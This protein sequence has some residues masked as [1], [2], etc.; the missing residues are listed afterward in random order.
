VEQATES[1]AATKGFGLKEHDEV[2]IAALKLATMNG[3]ILVPKRKREIDGMTIET[4][5]AESGKSD[6]RRKRHRRL[7]RPATT[8][9]VMIVEKGRVV[10][11]AASSWR[12]GKR[13][14][15]YVRTIHEDLW[16]LRLK[17]AARMQDW[18]L[19]ESAKI[20]RK[21]FDL[22]AGAPERRFEDAGIEVRGYELAVTPERSFPGVK[23][24]HDGKE[25]YDA[26]YERASTGAP[27]PPERPKLTL[28][29]DLGGWNETLQAL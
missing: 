9:S 19:A 16:I 6:R 13:K 10:F 29:M 26:V 28:R 3:Q 8:V 5:I 25:V 17:R 4:R 2:F 22:L 24:L 20:F 21:A 7:R 11:D 18:T 12:K 27:T 23:V 14:R 15:G 1:G